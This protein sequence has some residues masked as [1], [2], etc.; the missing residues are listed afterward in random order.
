M[1]TEEVRSFEI[2]KAVVC[3]DIYKNRLF[4]REVGWLESSH[5]TILMSFLLNP[6]AARSSSTRRFYHALLWFFS[7]K[8]RKIAM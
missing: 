5:E 3:V 7:N 1:T 2:R 8:T 4:V 6:R